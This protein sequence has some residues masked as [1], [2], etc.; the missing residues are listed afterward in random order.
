MTQT[1]YFIKDL[2]IGHIL[3]GFVEVTSFQKDISYSESVSYW[4]TKLVLL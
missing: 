2:V 1:V 4:V 3:F